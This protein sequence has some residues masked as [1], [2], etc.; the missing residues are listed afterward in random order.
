LSNNSGRN[1]ILSFLSIVFLSG[2][3]ATKS[4]P[5]GKHLLC[6]NTIK[7]DRP[8]L[9]E[10]FNAVIKQ[11][12][13]RKIFGFVRF[14]LSV[15]NFAFGGKETKFNNWLKTTVGEEPVL[16]DTS[17][18]RKSREQLLTLLQNNGF[19]DAVASD[20]VE[21]WKKKSFVYYY[22]Q[23]NTPYTFLK[24]KYNI[25]DSLVRQVVLQNDSLTLIHKGDNY[26]SGTLQKERD[27]VT[28]L[29]RNTGFAAFNSQYIR[30]VV[31]TGFKS[32][33]AEVT[34]LISNP[35]PTEEQIK[36][37][38]TPHHLLGVNKR[39]SIDMDYE[40]IDLNRIANSDSA[41]F[42]TYV[43]YPNRETVFL[44][45]FNRLTDHI[46]IQTNLLT[47]SPYLLTY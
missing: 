31:D 20:S 38:V 24:L 12:P 25:T 6:K 42:N 40:P 43:F 39:I 27:R 36:N 8:E 45:K 18:V 4:V 15:Y 47:Y 21:Y 10:N 17:K 33:Q 41:V 5:D 9:K 11:K 46:Y 2:C 19:F 16:I 14:H 32:N 44:Y 7:T 22:L 29:L 28:A 23:G 34:M 37:G 35:N 1:P 3:S 13:N 26:S 30:F